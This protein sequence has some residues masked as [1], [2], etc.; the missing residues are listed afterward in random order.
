ML[1]LTSTEIFIREVLVTVRVNSLTDEAFYTTQGQLNCAPFGMDHGARPRRLKWIT[2]YDT[3][4]TNEP[5]TVVLF[6]GRPGK[7]QLDSGYP[8]VPSEP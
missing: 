1:E 3:I 6:L 2:G 5:S 8:P 7:S 4:S